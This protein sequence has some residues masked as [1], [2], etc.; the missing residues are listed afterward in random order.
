MIQT[1]LIVR[2]GQT[3]TCRGFVSVCWEYTSI[4]CFDLN[5]VDCRYLTITFIIYAY[6]MKAKIVIL[7]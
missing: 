6:I 3:C 2:F 1:F 4:G 7:I 5:T